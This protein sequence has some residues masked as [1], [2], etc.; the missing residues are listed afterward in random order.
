MAKKKYQ[1]PTD[2]LQPGTDPEDL[3]LVNT[4][5]QLET[6]DLSGTGVES[7]F[8]PRTYSGVD[9][10]SYDEYIG[11]PFSV[12]NEDLDDLRAYNQSGGE[13]AWYGVQKLVGKTS[14]AVVGGVGMLFHGLPNM[15]INIGAEAIDPEG[16]EGGYKDAFRSIFEN[17]FQRG[18]DDINSWMDEKL[19]HYYT[20]EEQEM[21]VW[22]QMLG[23]SANFWANDFVNGL[24]FGNWKKLS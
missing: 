4:I 5:Q 11:R 10:D 14:T 13:K 20:K 19:P 17:D 9:F 23:G 15:L 24:S 18:L 3:G 8:A 16:H 6:Q 22:K 12:E 1:Q 7:P 21:G 2:L